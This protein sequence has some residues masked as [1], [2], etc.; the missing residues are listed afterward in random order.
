MNQS[1]ILLFL[2]I[3][4][5]ACNSL[6]EKTSDPYSNGQVS[7][8]YTVNDDG[9]KDGHYVTF[10]G[11]GQK[12][13]EGEYQNDK[14]VGFWTTWFENGNKSSEGNFENGKQNGEWKFY[15]ENG[16]LQQINHFV[17][18]KA[19]GE[20]IDF[21]QS[22]FKSRVGFCKNGLLEGKSTMYYQNGKIKS[23]Y[24][25][26]QNKT[27]GP[28]VEYF[29]NGNIYTK[30]TSNNG[31]ITGDFFVYDSLD[32]TIFSKTY[33][34]PKEIPSDTVHIYKKNQLVVLKIMG[35]DGKEKCVDV[36]N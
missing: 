14:Q 16:K 30:G 17:D 3:A 24:H 36:K 10:Y 4:L 8:K 27:K 20:F 35:K 34:Y 6:T 33:V 2:I 5:S 31:L 1:R 12:R 22:G 25:Y 23:Q 21:D 26:E 29:S 19:E 28:F 7:S 32:P 15:Y 13:S 11:D 18:N 9:L